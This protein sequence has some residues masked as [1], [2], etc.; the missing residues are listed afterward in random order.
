MKF[1][2]TLSILSLVQLM[3][4]AAFL[5]CAWQADHAMDKTGIGNLESWQ[6]YNSYAGIAFYLAVTLWVVSI[7]FTVFGKCFKE[8]PSQ[9]AIGIPPLIMIAGF[10]LLWFT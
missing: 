4:I 5:R 2:T 8:T 9:I 6:Q 7:I 3:L 1:R 10:L